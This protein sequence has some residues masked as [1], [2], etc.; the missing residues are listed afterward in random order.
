MAARRLTNNSV[1]SLGEQSE[2]IQ[3]ILEKEK[4]KDV[5]SKARKTRKRKAKAAEAV[6]KRPKDSDKGLHDQSHFSERESDHD[7]D[8]PAAWPT[9]VEAQAMAGGAGQMV[10]GNAVPGFNFGQVDRPDWA[11]DTSQ[12][13]HD[14][15]G[16]HRPIH[17]ISEDDSELIESDQE[18]TVEVVP[19]VPVVTLPTIKKK[20]MFADILKEN[21]NKVKE[22]DKVSSKLAPEV[23]SG[24]DK[25]LKD[26]VYASD[27]EKL[28]KLYP[29]VDNVENMK[30]PR[31]DTEVYQVVEQHVRTFDQQLQSIQKGIVAAISAISPLL[32]LGFE[33][34][35]SDLELDACAR[36]I[37][38]SV[39]LMSFALNGVSQRRRDLIKPSL[40]PIYAQVLT[41][42]HETTPEWLYGGNLVETTKK[43]EAAKRISE[44][45][46]AK[47]PQKQVQKPQQQKFQQ[48]QKQ[49]GRGRGQ[50]RGFNPYH[51]F[52]MPNPQ[53][54]AQSAQS[55]GFPMEYQQVP[56]YQ[57]VMPQ[58]GQNMQQFPKNKVNNVPK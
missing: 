26:C 20:G 40:A 51:K 13:D 37:W 44:K 25:Y 54:M 49:G 32:D 28:M 58:Q 55:M 8:Q 23:A 22:A 50:L 47:K 34:A 15:N 45:I 17:D 30:V 38:D 7:Q 24:V 16:V 53:Q 41:K 35:D 46:L 48:Q 18:S 36:G 19:E 1:S 11:D 43:C 56:R 5:D 27:M 21:L 33:R 6:G 10:L 57:F 42:G 39:Q 12:E 31:L 29:R 3:S 52:R 14:G 9:W 2:V 4:P